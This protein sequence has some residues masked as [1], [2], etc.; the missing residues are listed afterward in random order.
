V[1]AGAPTILAT[2]SALREGIRTRWEFNALSDFAVDLAGVIG[3]APRICFVATAQDDDPAVLRGLYEAAGQ[4]GLS[5]SHLSLNP[6]PNVDDVTGHLLSHDV[7]WVSGGRPATLLS[8]WRLH[9]VDRGMRAAW[10]AGVVLTGMSAG[11]ICWHSRGTAG[12]GER[13]VTDGLGMVPFS[14]GV[15]Y[16]AE[17]AHRPLFQGLI[18]DGTL[19]AGYATDDGA[20]VLYRG[21]EFI[22]AVTETDGAG[23]YFV[24]ADGD[25][26][27]TETR[28]PARRL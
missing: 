3:R 7:V 10:E 1:T 2:S 26:T 9:G 12:P 17:S 15:H 4:R 8:Q 20:A 11:S 21:T 25:G 19:P 16:G 6:V 13:P 23:T 5:A 28:L 27:V 24:T 14:N 18:G 22:E